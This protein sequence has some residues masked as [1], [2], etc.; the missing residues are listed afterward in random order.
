VS[1]YA[2]SASRDAF[3]H[4]F[5]HFSALSRTDA[6][7]LAGMHGVHQAG[8]ARYLVRRGPVSCRAAASRTDRRS[9]FDLIDVLMMF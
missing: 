8:A 4:L 9:Q 5:F 6:R 3:S 2:D 7:V 1:C